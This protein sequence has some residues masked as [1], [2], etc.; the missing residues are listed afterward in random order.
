[1]KTPPKTKAA[2]KTKSPAASRSK[3]AG[4]S[5][6][7]SRPP[8]RAG[9]AAK[10]PPKAKP[11]A[12]KAPAK[13]APAKPRAGAKAPKQAPNPAAELTALV[14][15]ALDDLKGTDV[16]VLDVR[17]L[18]PITDTMVICTGTSS[19][20]VK[21]LAENVVEKAGRRGIRP[22]GVEGLGEGEWVL[23]DLN[24]VLVHVMQAQARLFYQLEKLWDMSQAEGSR[25][26]AGF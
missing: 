10:S 24:G 5:P 18:T 16:K 17:E 1:M 2:A 21:S 6:A 22:I 23:V 13:K 25:A 11:A 4:K 26:A 7:R 8:A 9:A 15:S 19:R 14:L 12:R 20:H 3:P